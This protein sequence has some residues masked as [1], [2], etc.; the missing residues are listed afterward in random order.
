[1]SILQEHPLLR[2]GLEDSGHGVGG[3]F[4][5]LVSGFHADLKW[6]VSNLA[7]LSVKEGGEEAALRLHR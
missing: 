5:V 1:M 6:L 2:P 4:R 7:K 3:G